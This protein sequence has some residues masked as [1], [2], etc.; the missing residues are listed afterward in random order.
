MHSRMQVHGQQSKD[1]YPYKHFAVTSTSLLRW[2]ILHLHW[3]DIRCVAICK[4]VLHWADVAKE[5]HLTLFG[6]KSK[7]SMSMLQKHCN[8]SL[9]PSDIVLQWQKG[10]SLE[11]R[12]L[13]VRLTSDN[14]ST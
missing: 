4:A 12:H 2:R 5:G 8:I 1:N 11:Q 3:S 14:F 7:C 13:D 9:L 10:C 6:S